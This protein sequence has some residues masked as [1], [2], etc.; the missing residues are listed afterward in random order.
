MRP[1]RTDGRWRDRRSRSAAAA[2]RQLPVEHRH[3]D[4]RAAFIRASTWRSGNG[5]SLASTRC[6][7]SAP[8]AVTSGGLVS[9]P[10]RLP[11]RHRGGGVWLARQ[12][13][14]R[15]RVGRRR[16]HSRRDGAPLQIVVEIVA[17]DRR[18]D[19]VGRFAALSRSASRRGLP[20]GIAPIG[21][22]GDAPAPPRPLPRACRRRRARPRPGSPKIAC[23]GERR[24]DALGDAEMAVVPSGNSRTAPSVT[25][26][27][28]F[29]PAGA[30]AD[31]SSSRKVR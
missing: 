2:A 12:W 5:S 25:E 3:R 27:S 9:D 29:L 10:R 17:M 22:D 7:R 15:P 14:L 6:P 20:P 24:L 4:A 28:I 19:L 23:G 11:D 18:H 16:A 30:F 8:R 1:G 31:P 26:P 21:E 13:H